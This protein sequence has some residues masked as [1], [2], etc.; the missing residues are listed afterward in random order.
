MS[1]T[2]LSLL[3]FSFVSA[4]LLVP[5]GQAQAQSP[6]QTAAPAAPAAAAAAS[7]PAQF[8]DQLGHTALMSLTEKGIPRSEREARVREILKTN[9]DEAA[10]G[11]F[12]LGTYWRDATDAQRSEYMKLFE[13]MIVQTYTT[14]FENYSGQ[15]LKIGESVP[16]G[17]NDSIVSSQIQ[18][19]DGPPIDVQWRVRNENGSYRVV[20]VVVAGVSMSVTQR[21]DFVSTIQNG[22]GKVDALL[23]SMRTHEQKVQ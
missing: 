20:D 19:K 22:G 8:I 23:T 15:M 21:S 9:F 10:I 13:D 7:G 1:K 3:C 17:D 11:K 14:R 6:P 12:A 5:F 16:G 2:I 18:Q 4:L